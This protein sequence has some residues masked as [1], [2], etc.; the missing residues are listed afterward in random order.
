MII[1]LTRIIELVVG[2]LAIIGF[3]RN[4]GSKGGISAKDLL[5]KLEQRDREIE[6]LKIKL[7]AERMRNERK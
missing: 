4:M 1:L 7:H 5:D 6:D 2:L 3:R